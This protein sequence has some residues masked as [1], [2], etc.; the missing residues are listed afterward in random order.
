MAQRREEKGEEEDVVLVAHVRAHLLGGETVELLPFRHEEDVR[1][2]VKDFIED[3]AK[4]GFLLRDNIFCPWNQVRLVEVT[5]V[6]AL[7]SK[8]AQRYAD[9]WRDDAEKQLAFWKTRKTQ[10]KKDEK[11]G[12]K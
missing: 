2:A 11:P 9:E 6:T 1:S 8:Q 7:S 4:S 12:G 10:E 3:W 5:S